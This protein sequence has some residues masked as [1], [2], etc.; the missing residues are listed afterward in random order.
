MTTENE[1]GPSVQPAWCRALPLQQQ[2]V[3]FLAARGPDGISKAHPCK[4]VVIAYRGCV[5]NAAKYG[6][7]LAF[8][9]KAD[10]F[11]SLDVFADL[12]LWTQA[13]KTFLLYIDDLPFHYVMHLM[14]GVQILG[15]KH[16]DAM[17]RVRWQPFY[18][19]LVREMH[20][21]IETEDEMDKRL[22]DW[23]RRWW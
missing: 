10:G 13:T 23:E 5:L 21:N 1:L 8:G 3:L 12:H 20:L 22:G 18:E 15:F 9:E 16:P 2:S 11:M 7:A 17:Y 4:P 14:H 19:D 6:R